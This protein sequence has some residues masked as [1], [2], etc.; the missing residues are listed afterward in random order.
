MIQTVKPFFA[1]IEYEAVDKGASEEAPLLR[2]K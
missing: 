1:R 2:L